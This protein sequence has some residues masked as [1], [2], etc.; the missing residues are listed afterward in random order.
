MIC[1]VNEYCVTPHP[2]GPHQPGSPSC[3]GLQQDKKTVPDLKEF[4]R[5]DEDYYSWH[6]SAVNDLGKVGLI[7]FLND[8][9]IITKS[10]ELATSVFYAL[11]AALQNGMAA[12]FAPALYDGNNYN[13]L[14]LWTNIEQWYDT[15]VDCA[16]VVLFEVKRLLSL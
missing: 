12:N 1:A 5:K 9:L 11:W 2:S 3:M 6:D 4:T 16:N 7:C 15:L 13:P 8:T 14:E 10:P